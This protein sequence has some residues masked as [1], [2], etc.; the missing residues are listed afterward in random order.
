MLKQVIIFIVFEVLLKSN[1]VNN[2]LI[3]Q[4]INQ[5]ENKSDLIILYDNKNVNN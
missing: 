4:S 1:T 2:I 5:K 3:F